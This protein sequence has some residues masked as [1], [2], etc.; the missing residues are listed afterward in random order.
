MGKSVIEKIKFKVFPAHVIMVEVL[1]TVMVEVLVIKVEFLVIT[2]E[3][4]V[5]MVGGSCYYNGGFLLLLWWR[6]L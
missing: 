5:V 2:V 1:A 6:C 4:L 3:V